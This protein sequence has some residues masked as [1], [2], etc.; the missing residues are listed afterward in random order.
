[1]IAGAML[2]VPSGYG[3]FG[4]RP[5]NVLLAYGLAAAVAGK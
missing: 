1:V 4:G 3:A 5:G 2:F